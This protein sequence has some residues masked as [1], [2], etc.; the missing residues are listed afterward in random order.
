MTYGGSPGH[1]HACVAYP[2]QVAKPTFACFSLVLERY[3]AGSQHYIALPVEVNGVFCR[4][5][6]TC[7]TRRCTRSYP[8]Y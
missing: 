8:L 5:V 3:V 7:K 4:Y 6:G 2:G 1:S